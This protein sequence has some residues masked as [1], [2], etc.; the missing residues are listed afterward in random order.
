[1]LAL[2]FDAESAR[3]SGL[4][5]PIP[6]ALLLLLIA[7]VVAAALDAVGAL[8]VSSLL[9]VP[10]ATVRLMTRRLLPWQLGSVLL[11]AAEGVVGVWL[12]VELNVPPGAAIAM[13]GSGLFVVV[14]L[15]QALPRAGRLAAAAA[16]VLAVAGCG[17]S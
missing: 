2:G 1:W 11:V 3:A 17:S 16:A 6:D 15:A 7:L 14:A 9:V 4:R 8:L 13:L 10:A 12:S 5:S